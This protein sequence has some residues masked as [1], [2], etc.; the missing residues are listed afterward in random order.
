MKILQVDTG[1]NTV[2]NL[3]SNYHTNSVSR[4]E[5]ALSWSS[6]GTPRAQGRMYGLCRERRIT[7]QLHRV[8]SV[9][10]AMPAT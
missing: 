2:I 1:E 3:H 4:L 8:E 5:L 9:V 10:T 7:R 6:R